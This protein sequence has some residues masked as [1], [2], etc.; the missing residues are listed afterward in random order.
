MLE[1][2]VPREMPIAADSKGVSEE[3]QQPL[4]GRRLQPPRFARRL[5]SRSSVGTIHPQGFTTRPRHRN[6]NKHQQPDGIDFG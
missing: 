5:L 3:L 1:T 6:T 2:H 4:A